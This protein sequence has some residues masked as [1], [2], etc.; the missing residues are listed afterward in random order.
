MSLGVDL[1]SEQSG[2]IWSV[3][4]YNDPGPGPGVRL[5]IF[6]TLAE[7]LNKGLRQVEGIQSNGIANASQK[8]IIR[9]YQ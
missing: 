9:S 3:A 6:T 7:I 8:R 2:Y 5:P 1:R 4:D